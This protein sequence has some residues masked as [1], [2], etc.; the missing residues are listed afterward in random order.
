[1][2]EMQETQRN[3][4]RNMQVNA[5][6]KKITQAKKMQRAARKRPCIEPGSIFLR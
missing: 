2:Q 5:T 6:R 3:Y 1:M 4:A